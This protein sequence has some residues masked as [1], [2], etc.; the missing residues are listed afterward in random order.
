M[1]KFKL[2]SVLEYRMN[3]E[4]KIHNEFSDVNRHLNQQKDIL[5]AMMVERE[6]LVNDLRTMQKATMRADD[7]ATL[8]GYIENLRGQEKEQKNVIHQAKEAVEAKRKELVEAVKN[9]KVL[10]NLREK[11]AEEYR[12]NLSEVEQKNSDEMSVLKFGRRET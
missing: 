5:K 10:E 11:H 4:E 7:I 6:R 8:V 1:F 9:K 3:I 2:Q 12:K